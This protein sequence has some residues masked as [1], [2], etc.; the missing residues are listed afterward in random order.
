MII[1]NQLHPKPE[2]A[3]LFFGADH[4]NAI[5]VTWSIEHQ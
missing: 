5:R 4:V 3:R 1:T 2:H